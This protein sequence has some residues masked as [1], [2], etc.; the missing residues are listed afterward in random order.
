MF[1]LLGTGYPCLSA[2]GITGTLNYY[3]NTHYA[4]RLSWALTG[5]S[6]GGMV[7]VPA[8]VWLRASYGF[9]TALLL[10]AAT[11]VVA[12]LIP[13][14]ALLREQA[15]ST[16]VA[17]SDAPV[18]SPVAEIVRSKKF[19]LLT[20]GGACLLGAQVGLLAHQI[21][22]LRDQMSAEAAAIGV[23][24]T[25]GSAI[26][27]R[28][29]AGWLAERMSIALLSAAAA[30]FQGSG[31]L[32]LSASEGVTELYLA[33]VLS[34]FVV[35]AI[36]MLPP[37]LIRD[38]FGA[39]RYSEVYGYTNVGLYLGA[40]TG[41]A[42]SGLLFDQF[43]GYAVALYVL[44]GMHAIGVLALLLGSAGAKKLGDHK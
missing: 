14:F 29:L 40:G 38:Q 16:A 23:S 26:P 30:I 10:I 27:G 32:L 24:I 11:L 2:S 5:A 1:F 35:G 3:L 17:T 6:L 18:G 44:A 39:R 31:M 21:P 20:F 28:F 8:M 22:M 7:V 19:L 13:S 41:P 36:V 4:R 15:R 12:L 33:C 43:N 25:A 34:G 37:L 42:I 9:S